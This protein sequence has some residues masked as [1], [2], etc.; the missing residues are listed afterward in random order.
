MKA[1]SSILQDIEQVM[2][3]E[4]LARNLGIEDIYADDL[5][6]VILQRLHDDD[7]TDAPHLAQWIKDWLGRII[8]MQVL[9]ALHLEFNKADPIDVLLDAWF[10][11]RGVGEHL[12]PQARPDELAVNLTEIAQQVAATPANFDA[13]RLLSVPIACLLRYVALFY[14]RELGRCGS[15]AQPEQADGGNLQVAEVLEGLSLSELCVL[16]NCDTP[17]RAQPYNPAR[18]ETVT[19]SSGGAGSSLSRL[20]DLST[21][22]TAWSADQ[23]QEFAECLLA[24]LR[25]WHGDDPSTPKACAVAEIRETGFFTQL[26]CHDEW[27]WTVVLKG[28][29]ASFDHGDDVLV[30]ASDEGTMWAIRPQV[31]PKGGVWEMPETASRKARSERIVKMRTRDQ[32][33]ISY[34]HTD[35]KWLR[36][37]QTHL[38]PYVRNATIKVWDDTTIRPGAVWKDSIE[39]ALASAKVAVL[40]VSPDF[41]ASDFIASKEIPPLLDAAKNKGVAILW[42]PVRSSAFAETPLAAYQAAYPPDTPLAGLSAAKVDGALVEICK[43]I[44]SEYQR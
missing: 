33:F 32:V 39:N 21:V 34:S 10:L 22:A 8:V 25:Q 28:V 1:M 31:V 14:G 37:L 40:L 36:K 17:L 29:Q 43:V 2:P 13:L 18:R 24:V 35:A 6:Y 20:A 12:R 27:G 19:L 38:K 7:V 30:R 9:E 42:V 11:H 23:S 5:T 15:L 3:P 16:L 4:D 41:L 44:Q 26:T